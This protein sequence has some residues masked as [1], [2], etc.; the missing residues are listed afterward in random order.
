MLHFAKALVQMKNSGF[1]ASAV[2]AAAPESVQ[3]RVVFALMLNDVVEAFA[4]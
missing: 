1:L 3:C 2:G 4:K